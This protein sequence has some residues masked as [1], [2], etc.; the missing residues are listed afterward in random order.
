[1]FA[2]R[3]V[4]QVV[5]L[6]GNTGGGEEHGLDVVLAVGHVGGKG[7][8]GDDTSDTLTVDIG[9]ARIQLNVVCR[10]DALD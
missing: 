9:R 3:R 1:M 6:A 4:V 7:P 10:A 2:A 8:C 5:L